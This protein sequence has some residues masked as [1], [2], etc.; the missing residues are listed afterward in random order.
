M[1]AV[2]PDAPMAPKPSRARAR[3]LATLGRRLVPSVGPVLYT[4]FQ[5]APLA[6][7]LLGFKIHKLVLLSG[8]ISFLD[9]AKLLS[10]DLLFLLLYGAVWSFLL[11]VGRRAVRWVVAGVFF[12][13]TLLLGV[14]VILEHGFFVTTGSYLDFYLFRY[15]I[16]HFT[17]LRK[18]ILSAIPT[19]VYASLGVLVGT[20]ALTPL[21]AGRAFVRRMV[22]R[23]FAPTDGW[24]M[25]GYAALA[26]SLL[27][28]VVALGLR[29]RPVSA[30][31]VPLEPNVLALLGEG[32]WEDLVEQGTAHAPVD[33]GPVEP[34]EVVATADARP[35]NV[36]MVVMES[37]RAFSVTPYAPD[38]DTTPFLAELASRGAMA[39]T[40]YTTIPHTTKSIVPIH[41][42]IYPKVTT[43]NDEAGSDALPTE[44][45]PSL[46]R[47]R[48]Y[49]TAL[50]Q[51]VEEAYEGGDKFAR[52]FGYGTF[53][54]EESL[55]TKGFDEC[56]YFGYEDDIL[57]L[58]SL[59]WVDR[60]VRPFMLTY[61][62][63]TPHHDYKVP[64]GFP[65]KH[66]VDDEEYNGYLNTLRYQ[67]RFIQKVYKGLEERGLLDKTLFV[68]VGDHG[69]GFGEHKRYQHDNVIYE[70]GLRI[71]MIVVGPG[72]P[73]G[74][75]VEGLRQNVDLMPTVL[76]L[77][78][79]EIRSGKLPG[80]SLLSTQGHEKLHFSCYYENQCM[81]A[82][83]GDRKVV[84]HYGRRPLEVFDLA[85][86]P[87]ETHNLAEDGAIPK[88]ELDAWQ[89][90]L[91]G[92]KAQVN[93]R[94]QAH[95]GRL[96]DHFVRREP[97]P[98]AHE[99]DIRLGDA[100]RLRGYDAQP[101]TVEAGE[102]TELSYDFEVLSKP[103]PGWSLFVH[104]IGPAGQLVN[105]DHVPVGG[106]YPIDQWQQ[107][108]F[109]R[110]RQWVR[111]PVTAAAGRYEVVLGLWSANRGEGLES[112]AL[113]VGTGAEIDDERR[114]HIVTLEIMPARRR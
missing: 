90:D 44:C 97:F 86:D 18:V 114:V 36:V 91:L 51:S 94:Y 7:L 106:G 88:Q 24:S 77:L 41:C 98:S 42:G 96:K 72:V 15:G 78:G 46:L 113:P 39:R 16:E 112:R 93:A 81:A 57:L 27:L 25:R 65:T 20:L 10:S 85:T 55:S 99:V 109:I 60:Q 12:L 13:V 3:A 47:R 1:S 82:R 6:V 62:T 31:L 75:I 45:L 33:I 83:E 105:A 11:H 5:M 68:L 30:D 8:R 32:M 79:L 49:A 61:L 107:G 110:D 89:Q 73:E 80:K 56:S 17:D 74:K 58:P 43:Q 102:S 67:D 63:V 104:V 14:A 111:V 108:E 71:P 54:G 37:T 66:Y 69:E 64:K 23:V 76:E 100:I 50:F 101:T 2:P 70:E 103:E 34:L 40:A 52:N 38:L 26:A 19:F 22:E 4:L 87:G 28:V 35:Y 48:G 95:G 29:A 84:Y 53:M 9:A 92:W 21:L 59:D